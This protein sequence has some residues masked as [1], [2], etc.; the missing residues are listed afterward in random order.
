MQKDKRAKL[1]EKKLQAVKE[2]SKA[3]GKNK[4]QKNVLTKKIDE[5]NSDGSGGAFEEFIDQR[6]EE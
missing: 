3:K 1:T 6:S 4:E 5:Q 2:N